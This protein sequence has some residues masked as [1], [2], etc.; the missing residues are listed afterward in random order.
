MEPCSNEN[1]QPRGPQQSE[2]PDRP[3]NPKWPQERQNDNS[4]VEEVTWFLEELPPL[5]SEIKL[6][7]ILK[8]KRRPNDV[9]GV[10]DCR[11]PSTSQRTHQWH[12]K[13]GNHEK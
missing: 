8:G 10:V 9:V 7:P 2:S 13:Q 5:W 11:R 4:Q 3:H 1:Q 12:Q 6:R